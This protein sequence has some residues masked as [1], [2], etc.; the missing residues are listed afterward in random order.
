MTAQI[1]TLDHYVNVGNF[2][3]KCNNKL[4]IIRRVIGGGKGEAKLEI[5]RKLVETA[6]G[7]YNEKKFLQITLQELCSNQIVN[8]YK[9]QVKPNPH[10]YR[11]TVDLKPGSYVKI[12][13]IKQITAEDLIRKIGE[14]KINNTMIKLQTKKVAIN[15]QQLD[16]EPSITVAGRKQEAVIEIS[17]ND[18]ERILITASK[19]VRY[20]RNQTTVRHKNY[21]L[22]DILFQ[23]EGI[24]IKYKLYKTF[25]ETWAHKI[26]TKGAS[27]ICSKRTILREYDGRMFRETRSK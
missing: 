18:H 12:T 17:L 16:V 4:N 10:A 26:L 7:P 6:V 5:P 25:K 11:Y 1:T 14:V 27:H 20:Q 15:E 21:M 24:I 22:Q 3:E 2:S 19:Q 9:K 13:E 8:L 23:E